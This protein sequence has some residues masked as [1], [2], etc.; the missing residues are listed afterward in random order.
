MSCKSWVC[1]VEAMRQ[2]CAHRVL[3]GLTQTLQKLYIQALLCGKKMIK[4]FAKQFPESCV[5]RTKMNWAKG[6]EIVYP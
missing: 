3:E 6:E 1:I 4:G 5:V 2:A